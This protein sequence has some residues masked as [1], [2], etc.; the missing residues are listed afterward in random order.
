MSCINDLFRHKWFFVS[1][2]SASQA[3]ACDSYCILRSLSDEDLLQGSNLHNRPLFVSGYVRE[4]K[5][6]WILIDNGSAVNNL[7]K[8]TMNQLGIL[9]EELSSSKLVIQGFNQSQ[10]WINRHDSFG[11][12]HK[13]F[14]GKHYISCDRFKKHIQVVIRASM[15]S[16]KWISN[17]YALSMF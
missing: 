5:P 4:Q 15:N 17:L 14:V 10:L 16:W 6:N 8:S 9:I 1:T 7:P 13:R 11:D 2:I 3:K 12:R